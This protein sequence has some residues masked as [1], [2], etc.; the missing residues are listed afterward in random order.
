MIQTS[1]IIPVF[2]RCDL[3][4][5][6]LESLSDTLRGESCEILVVD[7]GSSDG[8]GDLIAA[9]RKS[10]RHLS[11]SYIYNQENLGFAKACNLGAGLAEGRFLIFLNNDIIALPGWMKPLL[12]VLE[13]DPTVG[14]V[15]AKLLYPDGTLQHAG[16]IISDVPAPITPGHVWRGRPRDFLPARETREYQAVTGACLGIR[17]DLFIELGGFDDQ[18]RND[19]EDVDLCFRVREK[20]YRVLYVASSELIH[21]ESQTPGRFYH[22][23]D[24]LI[25]LNKKWRGRI[26]AEISTAHPNVSIILV[27]YHGS[28]DTIE[29]LASIYGLDNNPINSLG[30]FYK[31]FNVIVVENGSDPLHGQNI[32]HWCQKQNIFCQIGSPD[33]PPREKALFDKRIIHI[34][35][36]KNLGFAG[37]CNVG[38]RQAMA[39]GAHYTWLLNNDTVVHPF[40]LWHLVY[41]AMTCEEKGLKFALVGSMLRCYSRPDDVQFDGSRVFYG[42]RPL[43]ESPLA[44]ELRLVPFVSSASMLVS[45]WFW[46]TAGLMDEDFFLYYEDNELCYRCWKQGARI[47]YQPRSWIYHKG[48]ASIGDWLSSPTS[49]YYGARNFL[50]FH[51]KCDRLNLQAWKALKKAV[52]DGMP[53]T[54]ENI[55]AFCEGVKDYLLGKKGCR[56]AGSNGKEP[57]DE[58]NDVWYK[59]FRPLERVFS[60]LQHDGPRDAHIEMLLNLAFHLDQARRRD[61][62]AP[63]S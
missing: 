27:D 41:T 30:L 52:W 36:G 21:L 2:N 8:T 32:Q 20:G 39:M 16:V 28:Q 5:E 34:R 47:L 15:G 4:K 54:P 63:Q 42:G 14:I 24:N 45:K 25:H 18:F 49:V 33:S 7:N 53:Q 3:T 57:P 29:C 50:L 19:C 23:E 59:Y 10:H 40:S 60:R 58:E 38:I 48:G 12:H 6:C 56:D 13:T 51:E 62:L 46:D 26:Q 43:S 22:S 37:G 1:I 61:A 55:K 44:E 17:K 11:I 9:F 35:T 31:N